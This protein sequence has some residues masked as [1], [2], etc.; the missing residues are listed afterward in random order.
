MQ[1]HDFLANMGI[2]LSKYPSRTV[3]QGSAGCFFAEEILYMGKIN[4]FH[5]F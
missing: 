2:L 4:K 3:K 1:P 5:G